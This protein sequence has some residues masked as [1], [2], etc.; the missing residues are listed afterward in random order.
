M[1]LLNRLVWQIEMNL[2]S[3]LSLSSLSERCGVNINHMCRV[4]QF[5]TGMSIKPYVRA[6]RLFN[7]AHVIVSSDTNI[8]S[9]AGHEACRQG[10][11]DCRRLAATCVP[12]P[13]EEDP[14]SRTIL[15]RSNRHGPL[16]LL[17]KSSFE[18]EFSSFGNR[19]RSASVGGR[20][21]L[22]WRKLQAPNSAKFSRA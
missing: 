1:P 17:A 7:A 9:V 3:E 20:T 16:P 2:H 21:F 5:S 12:V 22:R 13:A 8:L 15:H 19:L 14:R 10:I 4:F 18:S 6:R 11:A